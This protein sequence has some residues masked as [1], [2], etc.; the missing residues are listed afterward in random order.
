MLARP[1]VLRRPFRSFG[2]FGW[3]TKAPRGGDDIRNPFRSQMCL[4]EDGKRLS[5]GHVSHWII[6]LAGGGRFS[7]WDRRLFFSSS[8]GS[9]P[10][11]NGRVY[12]FDFLLD[13]QT[14]NRERLARS[15]RRWSWHPAAEIFRSRGGDAVPPPMTCNIGLTNKCNLRCEICGSQK[16]LDETGVRRRHMSLRTF[17]AVAETIF[18]FLSI[19]ELNS[20]GDPL[21]H[22]NIDIVLTRVAEHG[23]DIKVQHNGT[24]LSER[25]VDLLLRQYGTIMLSLDA[26]GPKFDEVRRGGVWQ[27]AEP[28]LDRLFDRRNPRRLSIGVYPTLTR[29]TIGEAINVLEWSAERGADVVAFHRY[30]P[31]SGAAEQAPSEDEYQSLKDQLKLWC[32][33]NADCIRVLF[34]SETLNLEEPERDRKEF[35]SLE[36]AAALAEYQFPT[37]PTENDNPSGDPF[38]SCVAPRDYIEIGLEG[39]ISVCCRSQDVP[40]GYATSPERFADAWLGTNYDKIRRSLNRDAC[41]PY[42]L[43]NCESCIKFFAPKLAGQRRAIDYSAERPMHGLWFDATADV[44]IEEIRKETGLCYVAMIP[45]GLD[46]RAFDLWEDERRLGP[47]GTLHDEIRQRGSG[48]YHIGMRL[49]YFSTSDGSDAQRNQRIY[50][51]RPR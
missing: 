30:V 7:H 35:A 36:K 18:P 46:A 28:G 39:Q 24:L 22:P 38:L 37:F 4:F 27:L 3:V 43:P 44:R 49:V 14:W 17:E 45:P 12:S 15:A 51:L 23:C 20:Q 16:H 10:N 19:V 42:P 21:L 2:G 40:L 25:V 9:D 8:D 48:R 29:R 32:A 31:V 41:G 26:V 13:L 33:R 1:L 50:A 11:T 5:Q 34:E 47:G 6:A